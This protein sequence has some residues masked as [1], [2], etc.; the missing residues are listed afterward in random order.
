MSGK[1]DVDAEA[2]LLQKVQQAQQSSMD[3]RLAMLESTLVQSLDSSL[4]SQS[5]LDHRAAREQA[6]VQDILG[7]MAALRFF[8]RDLEQAQQQG[9]AHLHSLHQAHAQAQGNMQ[10]QQNLALT[11]RIQNLQ[12]QLQAVQGHSSSSQSLAEEQQGVL[13]AAQR[14]LYTQQ[15]RLIDSVELLRCEVESLAVE[16]TLQS[17]IADAAMTQH[18]QAAANADREALQ[19]LRTQLSSL[20]AAQTAAESRLAS[21]VFSQQSF[22]AASEAQQAK[23][24]A[25]VQEQLAASGATADLKTENLA[26]QLS[27]LSS[28][29]KAEQAQQ[30]TPLQASVQQLPKQLLALQHQLQEQQVQQMAGLCN[31]LHEEQL[32]SQLQ[33]CSAASELAAQLNELKLAVLAVQQKQQQQNSESSSASAEISAQHAAE[34][35]SMD[36]EVRQLH[37]QLL[38]QQ[39]DS[40]VSFA[41]A[42]DQV[43]TLMQ[44]LQQ[45]QEQLR[46]QVDAHTASVTTSDSNLQQLRNSLSAEFSQRLEAAMAAQA[47]ETKLQMAD[48]QQAAAAG[49]SESLTRQLD[50]GLTAALEKQLDLQLTVKLAAGTKKQHEEQQAWV[51]I[52][53]SGFKV[54]LG[55]MLSSQLADALATERTKSDADITQVRQQLLDDAVKSRSATLAESQ[56]LLSQMTAQKEALRAETTERI[57]S[58]LQEHILDVADQVGLLGQQII[59]AMVAKQDQLAAAITQLK[60]TLLSEGRTGQ[61]GGEPSSPALPKPWAADV[62]NIVNHVNA[63]L[64]SVHSQVAGAL[65]QNFES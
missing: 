29:V 58:A 15:S 2:K 18:S 64:E 48:V 37:Q 36:Q 53:F 4:A 33:H 27:S 61:A 20:Q 63:A 65:R 10:T 50:T 57:A 13:L 32:Q 34:V 25:A 46:L 47:S 56:Q 1:R 26:Q 39:Q 19:S 7:G 42:A 6:V 30:L 14:K 41:T 60:D 11:L 52:Q 45:L 49:L 22:F 9:L 3:Q 12:T 44:D 55:D 35:T 59:A 54:Q 43:T 62:D 24:F 5:G 31:E 38:Q 28:Q 51:A 21:A 23:L 17:S 40:D 8:C 16:Q